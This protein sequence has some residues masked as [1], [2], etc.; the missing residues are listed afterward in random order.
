MTWNSNL[1]ATG[2]PG[3]ELLLSL[4]SGASLQ[5]GH[6]NRDRP[7]SKPIWYTVVKF[8]PRKIRINLRLVFTEDGREESMADK[9]MGARYWGKQSLRWMGPGNDC[10]H[11]ECLSG[12]NVWG[13]RGTDVWLLSGLEEGRGCLSEP[14]GPHH[15][16]LQ[17]EYYHYFTIFLTVY[18]RCSK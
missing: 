3:H 8:F 9:I 2:I 17:L 15:K 13:H 14:H 4:M 6:S 7:S 18:L 1:P 12:R 16:H 5:D 10:D 11:D